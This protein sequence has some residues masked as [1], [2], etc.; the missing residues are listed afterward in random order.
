MA[1]GMLHRLVTL[2]MDTASR[3][4]VDCDCG[5][6]E[7]MAVLVHRVMSRQSR[8]FHT[9][10]HVFGFV[11]GADPETVLAAVFHDL[12]YYQVDEGL[13]PEIEELLGS[14][15]RREGE[16]LFL[17][18]EGGREGEWARLCREVFGFG[19]EEALDFSSGLNE[20]LSA[21]SMMKLLGP[22]LGAARL[23]AVAAC[24]EASIPFRGPDG[25]GRSA[26]E[27]LAARL[28]GM[29]GSG[30]FAPEEG[31]LEALMRRAVAFGNRDV[32]DFSLEDPAD[33][34]SN[35]WKLLP[36]SNAA[37][38]LRGT[39]SIHEYRVALERMLG[40]FRSLDPSRVYHGWGGS[41]ETRVLESLERATRRNLSW[42]SL[43]MEAK[44]FAAA[45]LEAVAEL[46]GG[47]APMALFMGDIDGDREGKEGLSSLLPPRP[48]PT[49][50]DPANPVYRLLRDGRLDESSFDLKNS[51]LALYLYE[52]MEPGVWGRGVRS[53]S[54]YFAGRLSPRDFLSGLP[55][56]VLGEFLD[57]CHVMVP[58][59]LAMLTQL[60][61]ALGADRGGKEST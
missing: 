35:T 36:E 8:Q 25:E 6:L 47:D 38:R 26:P 34:L 56:V 31:G 3:L 32:R 55:R 29:A 15:I 44:L 1:K 53:L 50:L 39:F 30:L 9:L 19:P 16:R 5:D 59:R 60:R 33:F 40:F 13:P 2:L 43:Y 41:P 23:V 28:E 7:R 24:I 11:E 42:A 4:E 48:L 61:G 22:H 21:L 14:S 57:A 52:R 49:W 45:L 20:Y 17:R 54:E 10:E 51:P 37:L 46:S 27:R 18:E 12:V 58:T